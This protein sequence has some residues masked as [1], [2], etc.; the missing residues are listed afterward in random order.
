MLAT[1]S[2]TLLGDGQ[3]EGRDEPGPN[4]NCPVKPISSASSVAM[5]CPPQP[6]S[7]GTTMIPRLQH[8]HDLAAAF[9]HLI[10]T[11][12]I[13]WVMEQ[14]PAGWNLKPLQKQWRMKPLPHY[15]GRQEECR[16][17]AL[18][19]GR[20]LNASHR[21]GADLMVMCPECAP[22]DVALTRING[23]GH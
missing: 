1:P 12:S 3:V 16:A 23:P 5:R 19:C 8:N 2:A 7:S 10:T 14:Q 4:A 11:T 17:R 13:D 22:A 20:D 6:P 15:H 9:T 21:F 18:T